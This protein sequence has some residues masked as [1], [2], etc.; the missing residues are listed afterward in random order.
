M[1]C[2]ALGRGHR[3][4][5][6][7]SIEDSCI[8]RVV[9]GEDQLWLWQLLLSGSQHKV[10]VHIVWDT[11]RHLRNRPVTLAPGS[12]LQSTH[13]YLI[14]VGRIEAECIDWTNHHAV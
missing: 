7:V 4:T 2:G 9:A 11:H 10:N 5:R 6:K 12:E 1:H 3:R 13:C 8:S 14:A